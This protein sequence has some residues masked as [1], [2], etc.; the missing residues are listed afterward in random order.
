MSQMAVYMSIIV[1]NSYIAFEYYDI[2]LYIYSFIIGNWFDKP[3]GDRL[4]ST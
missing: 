3:M 4:C 1:S 2:L